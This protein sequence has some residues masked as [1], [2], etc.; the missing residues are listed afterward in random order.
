MRLR[1]NGTNE[2]HVALRS[3]VAE[4]QRLQAENAR[5]SVLLA[6]KNRELSTTLTKYNAD[7]RM[8]GESAKMLQER[9]LRMETALRTSSERLTRLG[10]SHEALRNE[11]AK[12]QSD[13]TSESKISTLAEQLHGTE[14]DLQMAN[15]VI[16]RCT[17]ESFLPRRPDRKAPSWLDDSEIAA[18]RELRPLRSEV[19]SLDSRCRPAKMR[20]SEFLRCGEIYERE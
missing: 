15:A 3:S 4:V 2:A 17:R 1:D 16:E 20:P 14:K 5:L 8:S 6:A 13:S 7:A 18:V 11:H 19:S 12:L 9:T 10:A